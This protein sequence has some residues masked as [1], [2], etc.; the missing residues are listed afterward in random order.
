M[1]LQE[2]TIVI[3][4]E[5]GFLELN[6]RGWAEALN[7]LISNSENKII[8]TVRDRYVDEVKNK[9]NLTD[10]IVFNV[11]DTEVLTAGMSVLNL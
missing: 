6:D 2:N 5:I 11:S 1:L 10:A 7:A 9:F 3:I 4:D 8:I